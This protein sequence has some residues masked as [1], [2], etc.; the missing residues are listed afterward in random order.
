MP[1]AY[2]R[3]AVMR[4]I[5]DDIASGM[6]LRRACEK[7]GRPSFDSVKRWLDEDE[8]GALRTQYTRARA[9]QADYY[10]DEIVEIVD[11][12]IDPARARVRMD[13]RK[14]VASKL[15]PKRYGDRVVNTHEGDPE[16]PIVTRIE[17]LI[18][19]PKKD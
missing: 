13:G 11:N 15:L 3:V 7:E 17:Y 18:I 2:D 19:D 8:A 9:L 5:C 6:S 16:N 10:A 1:Y 14:W 12:E 4:E